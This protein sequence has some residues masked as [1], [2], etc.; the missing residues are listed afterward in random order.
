MIDLANRTQLPFPFVVLLSQCSNKK[1]ISFS[2]L[3][4]QK[5]KRAEGI[6]AYPK[7]EGAVPLFITY[8]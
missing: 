5:I 1:P 3:T 4:K 2:I 8:S 7:S 6:Q